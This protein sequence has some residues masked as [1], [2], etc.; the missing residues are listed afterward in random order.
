MKKL[1]N[2]VGIPLFSLG[3]NFSWRIQKKKI[4]KRESIFVCMI[5]LRLSFILHIV[6]HYL[7]TLSILPFLYPLD[8]MTAS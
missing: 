8:M 5:L 6:V 7:V 3:M 1:D 4:H 2:C